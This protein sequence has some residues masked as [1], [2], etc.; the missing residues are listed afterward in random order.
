LLSAAEFRA[1]VSGQRRDARAH[2][3]RAVLRMVEI[4]YTL[5]VRWRNYGYDR[6]I[7]VEHAS[8]PVISVGN[9][10]LGG[11]GKTPL[12]AWIARWLRARDIR[13]TLI[14]RGYGAEQGARN[15]EALEL[16]QKLPDVPHLQNPDRVTA[17]HTAVD[18]FECQVILL[19]D[20]FQ[21]RRLARDLDIVLLD[22]LEP[23]G[24]DHVFPR[25]MLREPVSSLARA[26]IVALSR[27]DMVSPQQRA[28]LRA[29]AARYNSQA[30]WLE[31]RHAPERLLSGSGQT[32]PFS[33]FV[34]QS[35]AAFCGIGNPAGFRHT[36]AQCGFGVSE[37]REFRDHHAY[38]QEDVASLGQWARE[39]HASALICTH[40]DLVKLGVDQIAGVPL[41]AVEIGVEILTG[42]PALEERLQAIAAKAT[43]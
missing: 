40:K 13:V 9:L 18:E 22:A 23:F 42:L 34:G 11:T 41:W 8:V 12:V 27:A 2:L 24:F 29:I 43:G 21:H 37:L 15:D 6:Q 28:E 26:D 19:D 10:T 38:T 7:G 33:A 5:A 30:A 36:L 16:E 17:A 25:G 32:A 31:M 35:V 14:S 39:Q 4:P 3:W 20:G 1:L